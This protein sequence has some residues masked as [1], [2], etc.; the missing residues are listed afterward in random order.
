MI[1][2]TAK[3]LQ[4]QNNEIPI[5]TPFDLAQIVSNGSYKLPKHIALL[6]DTI[7]SAIKKSESR[8][9][10]NM[11]PR[12][13]KSEFISKYFPAWYLGTFPDKRL[14][15]CSYGQQFAEFWGRQVLDILKEFGEELFKVAINCK[16]KSSKRFEIDKFKGSMNCV[17]ALGPLTGKGADLMIIDDPVKNDCEANSYNAR[18]KLWDWFR[19]TA[20]TRLEPFAT[21]ILVMTR[22]HEDDLCG[23]IIQEFGHENEW[24]IIKIPAIASDNDILDRLPGEALWPE[25]FNKAAI[26]KIRKTIG[27]LWF[28][29]LY[30]QDPI[31]QVG[32][33]FKRHWFSYYLLDNRTYIIGQG[34]TQEFIDIYSL[35][36]YSVIDLATSTK[37]TADFTVI[38]TF[39]ITEKYDILILD[40]IRSKFDSAD[41]INLIKAN[42]EKWKPKL[43]G[44]ESVQYQITLI[45]NALRFGLPVKE[46]KATKDKISRALPIAARLESGKIFFPKH[47]VWLND[48]ENELIAF[49]NGK[50]DDQ[51]D[52]FAYIAEMIEPISNASPVGK[53]SS[54]IIPV[55]K[56]Y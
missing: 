51:V 7:L 29:A 50:H 49:P 46:L 8:L 5:F 1:I 44:I 32:N 10:I 18:N 24:T 15:L 2:K 54:K 17:G 23:R 3:T 27:S 36:I 53:A 28:S 33:I 22:W 12:H 14:I 42:Y 43:I 9:I 30:Q 26:E 11:P 21:L 13:G 6:Q 4:K 38:L 35:R 56:R 45:K 52:A 40:I 19:A 48:F 20:M 41:H 16:A 39:G 47:A 25:R 37:E 55:S 31:A 34:F